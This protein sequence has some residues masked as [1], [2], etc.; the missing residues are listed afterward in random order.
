MG[1]GNVNAMKRVALQGA[2]TFGGSASIAGWPV[3]RGCLLPVRPRHNA[4]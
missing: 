1:N 4:N 2:V 3:R